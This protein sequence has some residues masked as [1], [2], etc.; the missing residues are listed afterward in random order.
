M[1]TMSL[2]TPGSGLR[3]IGGSM[4]GEYSPDPFHPMPRNF[5]S[6]S[7]YPISPSQLPTPEQG[8]GRSRTTLL[9]NALRSS[10]TL[11][12]VPEERTKSTFTLNDHPSASD[13]ITPDRR[14]APPPP[15]MPIHMPLPPTP[16]FARSETLF[17]WPHKESTEML[18]G[19]RDWVEVVGD[20]TEAGWGRDGKGVGIVALVTV[21]VCF[22]SPGHSDTC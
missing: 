10:D 4:L 1:Y 22:V 14:R 16:T 21:L 12:F 11:A 13:F 19:E 9:S 5:Q 17:D 6:L 7:S 20:G 2:S 3:S 15:P 18:M 8:A